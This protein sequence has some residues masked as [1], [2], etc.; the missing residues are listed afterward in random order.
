MQAELLVILAGSWKRLLAACANQATCT[1]VALGSCSMFR[2]K[3]KQWQACVGVLEQRER[4]CST[5]RCAN[6]DLSQC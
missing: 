3:S 2:P 4:L 1:G 5:I 6:D